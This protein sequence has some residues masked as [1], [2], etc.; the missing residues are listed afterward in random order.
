M[1]TTT[2]VIT[3]LLT[4]IFSLSIATTS[5]A[6]DS[7]KWSNVDCVHIMT[8]SRLNSVV[9]TYRNVEYVKLLNRIYIIKLRDGSIITVSDRYSLEIK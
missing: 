4:L 6:N 7:Y 9:Q 8:G 2:L 1:K 5:I 3:I